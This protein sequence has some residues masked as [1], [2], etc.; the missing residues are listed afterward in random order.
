MAKLDSFLAR[1]TEALAARRAEWDGHPEKSTLT[2][3]ASA[4]IAGITGARPVT[5]GKFY[6]VTDS[7]PG[8]AGHALGPTSPELMLGALASCIAHTYLIEASLK[9]IPLDSV[10]IAVSGQM[11]YG[12]VVGLPSPEPAR[13][14]SITYRAVVETPADAATLEAMHRAVEETCPVL[15][16]LRYPVS[17]QRAAK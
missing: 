2:I 11:D 12:P 17:V 10:E 3:T 7:A 9:N 1:K 5:M 4:H 8:L 16:T 13:F 14:A 6:L 15:N